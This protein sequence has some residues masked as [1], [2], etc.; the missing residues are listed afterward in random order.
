[1]PD[2]TEVELPTEE[3]VTFVNNYRCSVCWGMLYMRPSG[4]PHTEIVSCARLPGECSAI[5][6]VTAN[7][8]ERARAQNQADFV[9]AMSLIGDIL[10]PD[11]EKKKNA[12]I[13][14]DFGF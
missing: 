5:G 10:Y 2:R 3:A 9:E 4:K 13:L 12:D 1:M 8:I 14:S 11:R 6:F 7:Y